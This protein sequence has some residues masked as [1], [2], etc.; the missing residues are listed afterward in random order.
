MTSVPKNPSGELESRIRAFCADSPPGTR[1][2]VPASLATDSNCSPATVRRVLEKLARE[3]A[4]QRVRGK[5][6]FTPFSERSAI[7]PAEPDAAEAIAENLAGQIARG[8]VKLGQP[9]PQ[10]K[11]MRL[12][13][14]VANRTVMRAYRLL[15]E[16]GLVERV[17]RRWYVGPM[18]RALSSGPRRRAVLY[19]MT[20]YD[21]S[22]VFEMSELKTRAFLSME[23]ELISQGFRVEYRD[24]GAYESD[25]AADSP[26]EALPGIAIFAVVP[27]GEYG[28]VVDRVRQR[29]RRAAAG[30]TKV[31]VITGSS[32]RPPAGIA[33]LC[34]GHVTT[35][36]A[37]RLA[38]FLDNAGSRTVMVCHRVARGT[39]WPLLALLKIQTELETRSSPVDL[40][41]GIVLED[42]FASREEYL[43][44]FLR[45][46]RAEGDHLQRVLG[47][48]RARDFEQWCHGWMVERSLDEVLDAAREID[49]WVFQ[50][51]SDAESALAYLAD[52]GVR[53][54][55]E[56]AVISLENRERFFHLGLTSCTPDLQTI[57]YLMA[58]AVLGDVPVARTSHGFLR[59]EALVLPRGTTN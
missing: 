3:G 33:H 55:E 30:R 35:M 50:F 54:P 42:A 40:Q 23:R 13:F 7:A 57:G 5:G 8:E 11:L 53:V 17:G 43:G 21:F 32:A 37:R 31:L 41:W 24:S 28:T 25:F 45:H 48:T 56:T 16:R 38:E 29:L 19:N 2:P 49:T 52:R 47:P 20:A 14:R 44:Q 1:L 36:L 15:A 34:T 58:H 9:L 46:F 51:D 10:V 22:V 4:L 59:T 6:T 27:A 18:R 12:Q 26:D 39:L